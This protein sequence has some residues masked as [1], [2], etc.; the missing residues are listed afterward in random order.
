MAETFENVNLSL[1]DSLM[2]KTNNAMNP[3]MCNQCDYASSNTG[4]LRAHLKTHSG[5]KSNKC[6]QCD[7]ASSKAG[8]VRAHLK[9][10][11]VEKS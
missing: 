9:T 7:Y 6:N 3:N 4:N 5:E 10:H 2:K 8:N 11:S 1:K